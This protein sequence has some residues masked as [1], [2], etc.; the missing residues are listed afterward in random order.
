MVPYIDSLRQ[1]RWVHLGEKGHSDFHD[2]IGRKLLHIE[3]GKPNVLGQ[4]EKPVKARRTWSHRR[5]LK[6]RGCLCTQTSPLG[7]IQ[8]VCR[9]TGQCAFTRTLIYHI[10]PRLHQPLNIHLHS[11]QKRVIL[12]PGVPLALT[13]G[14]WWG[15]VIRRTSSW[16]WSVKPE[17]CAP[18]TWRR[19]E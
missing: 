2:E 12:I 15:N 7:A 3:W 5:N 18:S 6:Q 10:Q 4:C 17:Q 8:S 11:P 1:Q 16:Y 13:L 9:L 14:N 19:L